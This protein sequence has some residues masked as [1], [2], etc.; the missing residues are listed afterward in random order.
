MDDLELF[1]I[2]PTIVGNKEW[3]ELL[4][5]E[6]ELGPDLLLDELLEKRNWSNVE[7]VWVLKRM[8][9]Y[10]GKKDSLLSKAPTERIFTNFTDILRVFYLLLDYTNPELDDN[11]RSYISAKLADATWGI[12]S[13]TRS[14][15][16][17]L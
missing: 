9:F 12:N 5:K 17:K 13:R 14:Y 2:P 3:Q 16:S 1:G 4:D 11:T 10:Y 8:I 6:N 15:L 7:I